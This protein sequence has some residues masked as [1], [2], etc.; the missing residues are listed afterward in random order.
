M[1]IRDEDCDVEFLDEAD[2]QIDV[3]QSSIIPA[4][5]EYHISYAIEITKLAIIRKFQS[6]TNNIQ[7]I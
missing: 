2:F 3:C 7:L 5:Q 1:R 6:R 4:Q